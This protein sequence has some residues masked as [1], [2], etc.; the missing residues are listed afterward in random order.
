ML[1]QA[2][3]GLKRHFTCTWIQIQGE[4]SLWV[5]SNP[6]PKSKLNTELDFAK[7]ETP[8]S[9]FKSQ[10]GEKRQGCVTK[11]GGLLVPHREVSQRNEI[12]RL[13]PLRFL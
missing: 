8:F 5:K 10:I 1:V 9:A 4:K 2:V 3:K 12:R 6:D 13:I 11:P 7:S